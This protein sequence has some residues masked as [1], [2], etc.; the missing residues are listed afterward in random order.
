[1]SRHQ[2]VRIS[3]ISKNYRTP[4]R[5]DNRPHLPDASSDYPKQKRRIRLNTN[6][7]RTAALSVLAGV[8]MVA[9]SET[10]WAEDKTPANVAAQNACVEYMDKTDWNTIVYAPD[11]PCDGLT[12]RDVSAMDLRGRS[13]YL[14][15]MAARPLYRIG[16]KAGSEALACLHGHFLD[17]PTVNGER[18]P[19]RG[20]TGLIRIIHR[21]A[22]NG[23]L[24]ELAYPNVRIGVNWVAE[25]V[26]HVDPAL[27]AAA[28]NSSR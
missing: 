5:A 26:C 3:C 7:F 15:G 25:K 16:Q 18:Q 13:L 12:I 28:P 1:M 10:A 21:A 8:L 23:G 9:A 6:A 22:N 19:P 4:G 24:D 17:Y 14:F 2:I 20:M 11:T 27:L